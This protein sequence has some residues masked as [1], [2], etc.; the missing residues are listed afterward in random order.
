MP[1]ELDPMS[2]STL[3]RMCALKHADSTGPPILPLGTRACSRAEEGMHIWVS[4]DGRR[5]LPPA[6]G[7]GDILSESMGAAGCVGGK[8]A[9]ADPAVNQ[10]LHW[11]E[12]A[13]EYSCVL[14]FCFS[15]GAAFSGT[16]YLSPTI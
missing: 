10:L 16:L 7:A 15:K 6:C 13:E 2:A 12:V 11:A 1:Y 5:E 9:A 4:G 8:L 3:K 14:P